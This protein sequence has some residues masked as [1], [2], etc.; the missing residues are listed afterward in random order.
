MG[1]DGATVAVDQACRQAGRYH[2]V[3]GEAGAFTLA[4]DRLES[5]S[6]LSPRAARRAG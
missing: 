1:G 4:F 2:V 3:V 6:R 5:A